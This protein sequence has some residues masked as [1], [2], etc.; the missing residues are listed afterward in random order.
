MIDPVVTKKSLAL[1]EPSVSAVLDVF[2]QDGLGI[3]R[4]IP[5]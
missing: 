5:P 1:M 4:P 3:I 2:F